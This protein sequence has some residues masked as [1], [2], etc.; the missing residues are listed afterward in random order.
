MI[1]AFA[2]LLRN[3]ANAAV[4]NVSSIAPLIGGGSSVGYIASKGALN[5]LSLVLARVLGPQ[6]RVNV[7]AP[8]MVDSPWL[9]NGLG[10]ERFEAMLRNYESTSALNSLVL[11]EEVAETVYYLGA[12][13]SKTTGEVH[14]VDA[15]RRVGR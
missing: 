8:G 6:I 11:P 12:V 7:V 14:L 5:A 4:V 13:A 10:P 3:S 1:R 2:P 9:R 15:G